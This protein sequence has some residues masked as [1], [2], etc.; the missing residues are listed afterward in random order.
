MQA[1]WS[2]PASLALAKVASARNGRS[3]T[4]GSVNGY[5]RLVLD[6]RPLMAFIPVRDLSAAQSFYGEVLGL[7]VREEGPYAVVLDAGGTM[8]RLAQVDGLQPQPFTIA[9]WQVLDMRTSIDSL[10][11]R[12]VDFIRYEGMDQDEK[13]IWS[14]PGGDQVAW[15]KDLDGNTLSLTC[16]AG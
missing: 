9:G 3:G 1:G 4:T 2:R 8:L 7:R 10:A 5:D 15:F 13:G 16:F 12:G 6:D 14:T 11:S